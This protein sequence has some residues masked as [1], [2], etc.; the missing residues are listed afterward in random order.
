MVCMRFT[1]VL[2]GYMHPS[3]VLGHLGGWN[4]GQ[5]C[6][7]AFFRFQVIP[8]VSLDAMTL[9]A[10]FGNSRALPELRCGHAALNYSQM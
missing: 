4:H 10:F 5:C 9:L 1:D 2:W 3:F 6:S 8:N 7:Q